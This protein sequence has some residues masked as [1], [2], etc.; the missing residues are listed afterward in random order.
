MSLVDQLLEDSA[1]E[2]TLD[3]SRALWTE[4]LDDGEAQH[5]AEIIRERPDARCYHLVVALKRSAPEVYAAV[6]AELRAQ[7]LLDVLRR[8]QFLN[9]WGYLST[10]GSYDG[11]AA[12]ALLD[13][14]DAARAG[15]A[16]LLADRTPVDLEGSEESTLADEY[17]YR[18]ADFAYRYLAK[19]LGREAPFFA[20]HGERDAAIERLR[21]EL[22][23]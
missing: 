2:R 13:T 20:R 6:P 8:Q 3:E 19:I 7:V 21:A 5:A 14:G 18:R 17:G 12:E 4:T 15:L 10:S 16:E 1:E 9:D 22:G 11:P 23:V